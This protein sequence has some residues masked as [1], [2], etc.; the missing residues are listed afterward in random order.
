MSQIQQLLEPARQITYGIIALR[1][2]GYFL[3]FLLYHSWWEIARGNKFEITKIQKEKAA[4]DWHAKAYPPHSTIS[5]K[6]LAHDTYSNNPPHGILYI[7]FFASSGD[8]KLRKIASD[9]RLILNPNTQIVMPIIN[10]GD[11]WWYRSYI[12]N[13]HWSWANKLYTSLSW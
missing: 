5:P 13:W 1:L 10:C 11:W 4:K 9:W 7:F 8:R 3:N 12:W 2:S 6:K